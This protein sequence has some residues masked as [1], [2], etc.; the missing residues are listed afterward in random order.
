[1]DGAWSGVPGSEGARP[2]QKW[3][4]TTKHRR[5]SE[6]HQPVYVFAFSCQALLRVTFTTIVQFMTD[7][8]PLHEQSVGIVQYSC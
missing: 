6:I 3:L 2:Y 4:F 5:S 8:Y 7:R 1:M